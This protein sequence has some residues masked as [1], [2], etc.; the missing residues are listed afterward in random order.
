[1][2]INDQEIIKFNY[3]QNL[4]YDDFYI[5]KSNKHILDL[6]NNWP[7]WQKNFINII[8]EK[9]SGKTHLINIFLKKFKG[10]KILAK[11]LDNDH[12]DKIK[13]HQNI[14]IENLSDQINEKLFFTLQNVIEQDNKYLIVTS[15]KP[16]VSL[17]F[18]LNDLNSRSNNFLLQNIEKPDDELMFA[19]I[20]K[21]LSDRQIILDKKLIFFIIKKINRSYSEIFKFIYKIDELSLKK[22]KPIDL[23]IIKSVL[24]E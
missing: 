20:V 17:N 19:L 1:M 7:K 8:G 22:K 12:L 10:L 6:L 4:K 14:V 23:N 18:N 15:L 2:N 16:I 21:N 9:S 3:N 24:G 11:D 13:V 5:S